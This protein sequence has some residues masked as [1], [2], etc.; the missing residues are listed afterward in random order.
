MK[1]TSHQQHYKGWSFVSSIPVKDLP[2]FMLGLSPGAPKTKGI[3]QSKDV[4]SW[5][6]VNPREGPNLELSVREAKRNTPVL[7]EVVWCN[8]KMDCTPPAS[9]SNKQ[10]R[11]CGKQARWAIFSDDLHTAWIYHTGS[12]GERFAL[13]HDVLPVPAFLKKEILSQDRLETSAGGLITASSARRQLEAG[14]MS[15][16]PAAIPKDCCH[17]SP[18][19]RTSLRTEGGS[20]EV[21]KGSSR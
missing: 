19:S 18:R 2:L 12:H 8:G 9:A 20:S 17:L 5:N 3:V 13:Y 16:L 15:G 1:K 10:M 7:S 11:A 14:V 6:Q 4:S 21:N